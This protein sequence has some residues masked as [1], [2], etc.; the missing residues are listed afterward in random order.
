MGVIIFTKV[1]LTDD[2]VQIRHRSVTAS[3]E[4][5]SVP[6]VNAPTRLPTCHDDFEIER[7]HAPRQSSSELG[8]TKR[9]EP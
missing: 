5:P 7:F 9:N 2:M 8:C 3:S 6:Y 4:I 1:D